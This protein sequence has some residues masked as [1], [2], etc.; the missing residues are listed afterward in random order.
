[1]STLLRIE[2]IKDLVQ[3]AVD[4]GATTVEQ[5]HRVIAD[6]PFTVLEQRGLLDDTGA[7]LRDTSQRSI[8]S[9][10]EAI[11]RI[12][13]EVGEMATHV[14]EAI[15]DQVTVQRRITEQER[16]ERRALGSGETAGD[17]P[18]APGRAT[19]AG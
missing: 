13:Q 2:A 11:R 10:Y 9:V 16:E 12:N 5:I 17:V 1:M 3:E 8:G 19:D 4:R 15:D 6:L 18:E 14:F 7:A